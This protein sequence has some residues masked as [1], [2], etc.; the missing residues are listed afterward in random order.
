[1]LRGVCAG[2]VD[3]DEADRMDCEIEDV[4]ERIIDRVRAIGDAI[5]RMGRAARRSWL[6][7]MMGRLAVS[8][9]GKDGES[10]RQ[11][12]RKVRAVGIGRWRAKQ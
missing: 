5:D 1:M 2:S 10:A 12:L 9:S 6:G 8:F 11:N 4:E 7:A 3:V